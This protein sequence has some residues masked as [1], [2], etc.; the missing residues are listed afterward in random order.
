ML[1]RLV[2]FLLPFT[3]ITAFSGS[4]WALSELYYGKM[5][6]QEFRL[7]LTKKSQPKN[8]R[9]KYY[10]YNESKDTQLWGRVVRDVVLLEER[11]KD[12]FTGIWELKI[13]DPEGKN[14]EIREGT[15][16][17]PDRKTR[18]KVR[19]APVSLPTETIA[20]SAYDNWKMNSKT[21]EMDF[22]SGQTT[23][24][25]VRLRPGSQQQILVLKKFR[26]KSKIEKINEVLKDWSSVDCADLEGTDLGWDGGV[27]TRLKVKF[28]RDDLVYLTR[29]AF[30][31]CT[32]SANPF[33][34]ETESAVVD[35][36]E[37]KILGFT[38]LFK[39][40][41]KDKSV[42]IKALFPQALAEYEKFKKT[43]KVTHNDMESVGC[44]NAMSLEEFYEAAD[45]G[46]EYEIK[47]KEKLFKVTRKFS[48]ASNLCG[49]LHVEIP[50]KKLEKQF[51]EEY[52]K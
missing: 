47:Y 42:I 39:D 29:Y 5:E 12:Q 9:G 41:E 32:S 14:I 51:K 2:Y 27:F 34:G 3:F 19:I 37:G 40:W 28:W 52:Y 17:S 26:D 31:N 11:E 38:D 35:L 13:E 50:L 23:L 6:G 10:F 21:D 30:G 45:Y 25:S 22:K 43:E 15:W 44:E 33:T 46:L 20:E 36:K 16:Y 24:R 4:T 49:S 18:K 1:N 7:L 8:L 48:N